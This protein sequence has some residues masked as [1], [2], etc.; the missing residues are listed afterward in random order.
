MEASDAMQPFPELPME[1]VFLIIETL[2]E[3]EPKRALDL[4]CLSRDIRPVAEKALYR[5]IILETTE[6]TDLFF[7]MIRSGCRLVTF[8][9]ERIKTLC[10]CRPVDVHVMAP[11][12][13]ACPAVQTIA[14]NYY[15]QR[16]DS[17]E[18][19]EVLDALASTGPCPS[20]LSCRL[21]W[22]NDG[23]RLSLLLFQSVTHLQLF[24]PDDFET[25]ENRREAASL[26]DQLDTPM[27][28]HEHPPAWIGSKAGRQSLSNRFHRRL[29]RLFRS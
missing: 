11:I 9:Q 14:V 29:H 24:D 3:I 27:C 2:L 15:I 21:S 12:F 4:V 10:F 18:E 20:R 8:Y 5:C 7:D 17:D 13:F 22:T 1:L 19:V 23:Q 26:V 28:H 16:H 25:F 6:M